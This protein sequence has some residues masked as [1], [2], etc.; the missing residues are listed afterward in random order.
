MTQQ[1]TI[2]YAIDKLMDNGHLIEVVNGHAYN[3][4]NDRT[5]QV[6]NDLYDEMSQKG[7]VTADKLAAHF[8]EYEK[9]RKEEL[10]KGSKK[11]SNKKNRK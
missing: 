5:R 4:Y 7:Y 8:V 9:A 6:L 3:T 10:K 1:E 2:S 11:G